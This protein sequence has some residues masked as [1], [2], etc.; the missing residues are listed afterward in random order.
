MFNAQVGRVAPGVVVLA[1]EGELDYHSAVQVDEAL[2]A[3]KGGGPVSALVVDCSALDY[4]DSTGV[5]ALLRCYAAVQE[6]GGSF[7]IA[8][9]PEALARVF[10]ITG[11]NTVFTC[12]DTVAA[13]L[14]DLA[15]NAGDRPDEGGAVVLLG[16]ADEEQG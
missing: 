12:H 1:M 7:C 4:C 11:L 14:K 9:V 2:V 15:P 8:E 10:E 3:V 13:A 16:P 6:V 5:S